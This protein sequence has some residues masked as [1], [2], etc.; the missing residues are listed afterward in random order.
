MN[1]DKLSSYY[2]GFLVASDGFHCFGFYVQRPDFLK[3]KMGLSMG[4]LSKS[5]TETNP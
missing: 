4:K 5:I 2:T 1:G 3:A